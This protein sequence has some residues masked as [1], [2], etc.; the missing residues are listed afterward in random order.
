MGNTFLNL[1][2]LIIFHFYMPTFSMKLTTILTDQ[3]ALL[4]LKDHVIHDP[5]NVLTTNWSA[6]APVCN[7]F[8]VSCGSKHRKVTALNLT[9]LGLV[10]TLPP[11]IG[12]LSFLSFLRIRS[13]S[14]RGKLPVQLSNLHR[15]KILN[16]GNLSKLEILSLFETRISGSIPSSI[17]NISS[18]QNIYLNN[19]MLSGF[20]PSVPRDLLLL[21]GIDFNFNNLSGHIP[22]DMFDH[23]PNLKELTLSVNLLSGRIPASLFKCKELQKL[24]LSYNQMEGS[25]PIEIGNLSMLQHIYIGQNHFEGNIC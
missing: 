6:S 25:L 3:S 9:G 14:F 15:L 23:L 21:E 1:S 17:F 5:K 2:L 19:N 11:H 4:A 18:L 10:G 12:N 8:G 13:N 20:I 16:F 22:E 24:S 7:W